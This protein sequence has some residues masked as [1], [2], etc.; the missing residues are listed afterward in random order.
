MP[1]SVERFNDLFDDFRTIA[2]RLE[3]RAAYN[4]PIEQDSI[5][6]FRKGELPDYREHYPWRELVADATA[7]GKRVE[8]VHVVTPPLSDYVK[9]QAHW[10]YR[11][12]APAGEDIRII[13]TSQHP[14]LSLPDEDFWMFDDETVV[15]LNYA[16]DDSFVGVE[17][18]EGRTAEYVAYRQ[19]ALCLGVPFAAYWK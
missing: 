17:L 7:A 6:A 19:I 9:Y 8:R 11:Q 18:I 5:R 3:V 13:D 15:R 4:I 16:D 10:A 1:L 2:F 12:A 14:N